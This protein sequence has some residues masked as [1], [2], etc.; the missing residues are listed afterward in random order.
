MKGRDNIVWLCENARRLEQFAGQWVMFN[1]REGVV[2]RGESLQAVM[3]A[4]R[5]HKM[6]QDPF[7][8][9]VPSKDELSSPIPACK[10]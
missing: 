2:S 9:H 3:K 10:K 8:F 5:R 4:C 7:I 6:K 1:T